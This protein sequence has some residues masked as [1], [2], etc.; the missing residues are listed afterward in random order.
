M[1]IAI[2]KVTAFITRS[3]AGVTE[4]LLFEH[5]HAGIQLPAGTVEV[6]ESHRAAAVREAMEETGIQQYKGTKYIGKMESE[7]PTDQFAVTTDTKVYSRPD[8]TSFDWARFL[9]GIRVNLQ[10][11]EGSFSQVSYEE[12]DQ[13]VHP[14][15]TT[16]H[17]MGWVPT[18]CLTNRMVRY[19]YHLSVEDDGRQSWVVEVDNHH[20]RL[21]WSPIEHLPAIVTPQQA[22]IEYV[23]NELHY[24]FDEAAK[25]NP[26]DT[27]Q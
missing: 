23:C 27:A 22:W 7:L 3:R 15:Y 6:A 4:L 12:N 21:F 13:L 18:D 10:R 19:F 2:E 11:V 25:S 17:I 1:S 9:R 26:N 24:R 16:Y 5:P 20:Y 14:N 8:T